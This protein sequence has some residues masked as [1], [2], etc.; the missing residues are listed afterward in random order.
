MSN[1]AKTLLSL[2]SENEKLGFQYHLKKRNKRPDARNIQLFKDL[3]K[4]QGYKLQEEIGLNAYNVLNKR[5][6]DRLIDYTAGCILAKENT[7]E[8]EIMKLIILSRKLFSFKAYKAA[9]KLLQLAKKKASKIQHYHLLNEIYHSLIEHSYH[10]YAPDQ[11]E[12]ISEFQLNKKAFENQSNLNM[13]YAVIRKE[14]HDHERQAAPFNLS[15]IIEDNFKKFNIQTDVGYNFKSLYQIAEMTD[16]SGALRKNYFGVDLFFEQQIKKIKGG[17]LDNED[18][19]IYHIDL[20]YLI[21]HIYFRKKDFDQSLA[22]LD[23][24]MV[25]MTR[26]NK[27]YYTTRIAKHQTLFA[28]NHNFKGN[29]EV[30]ETALDILS[31]PIKGEISRELLQAE[32]ARIMIHIQQ[33]E[34]LQA[35]KALGALKRSDSWYMDNIGTEWLLNKKFIE[36]LLHIELGNTGLVDSRVNS[37]MR[38][39]EAFFK[40][41]T[42]Q[43]LVFL[44][45][46]KTYHQNPQLVTSSEFMA[47]V[48]KAFEWKPTEE[49]DLFLISFYAW[50]KSK[51]TKQPLYETTL[52]LVGT[53]QSN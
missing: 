23:N 22:H 10:E 33:E 5:L 27:R 31:T 30:A 39:K 18:Q 46:I 6:T 25:Q 40:G 26:F 16:I 2:L 50:L 24:M 42:A 45:L 17:P 21:A 49:E 34:L 20:V 38:K 8:V 43:G 19:L 9:F 4:D 15:T 44:K 47:K 3:Q 52:N 13:A 32:L 35:K 29:Y 28:L 12:V 41:S 1:T 36:I 11:N 48:E 14:F 51:M 7:S 53:L 37:L